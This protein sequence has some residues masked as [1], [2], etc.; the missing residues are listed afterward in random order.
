[1]K[2]ITFCNLTEM[3]NKWSVTIC[4]AIQE[5]AKNTN[6]TDSHH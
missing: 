1:M 6:S 4:N 2:E 5:K 3:V